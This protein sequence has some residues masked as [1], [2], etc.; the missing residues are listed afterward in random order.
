[1]KV[2]CST[3]DHR[4]AFLTVEAAG[5]LVS[6]A[7]MGETNLIQGRDETRRPRRPRL[8]EQTDRRLRVL[9]R[10]RAIG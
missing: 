9:V 5:G 1:M 4:D 3:T 8:A 2:L 7:K 10:V 6:E